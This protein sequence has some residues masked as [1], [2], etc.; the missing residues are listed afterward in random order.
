MTLEEKISKVLPNFDLLSFF[1]YLLPIIVEEK[2]HTT[3][4]VFEEGTIKPV[5]VSQNTALRLCQRFLASFN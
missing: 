5:F 3:L 1:V 2:P 4:S